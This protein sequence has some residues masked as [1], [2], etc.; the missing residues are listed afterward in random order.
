MNWVLSAAVSVGQS[1]I[2]GVAAWAWGTF[3]A[4]VIVRMWGHR[5]GI[6]VSDRTLAF[7]APA[8][9]ITGTVAVLLIYHLESF[10]IIGIRHLEVRQPILHWIWWGLVALEPVGSTVRFLA[11]RRTWARQAA[12]VGREYVLRPRL[13]E[14]M[15]LAADAV[16]DW[17]GGLK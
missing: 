1:F 6:R 4:V 16:I 8:A 5:W 14:I 9:V 11:Y 15:M 2:F 10:S 12:L 13:T 3:C 7:V 17:I